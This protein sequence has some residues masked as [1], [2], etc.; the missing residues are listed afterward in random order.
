MPTRTRNTRNILEVAAEPDVVYRAVIAETAHQAKDIEYAV[1]PETL[2]V[3]FVHRR[4]RPPAAAVTG[5]WSLVVRMSGGC[6]LVLDHAFSALDDHEETL[7]AIEQRLDA[8][9]AAQLARV[10]Q[11]AERRSAGARG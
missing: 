5:A 3:R 7:L 2:S 10:R 9:A 4:P 6:L 1:E 8:E 11:A